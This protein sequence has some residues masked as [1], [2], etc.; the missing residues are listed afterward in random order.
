MERTID[1]FNV[2]FSP[3]KKSL[4]P[5]VDKLQVH[6]DV[7]PEKDEDHC[8]LADSG[9]ILYNYV[10]MLKRR[11]STQTVMLLIRSFLF[12]TNFPKKQKW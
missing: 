3:I 7:F 10:L 1:A 6:L 12:Q 9:F 11:K 2:L 8:K 4:S 5:L